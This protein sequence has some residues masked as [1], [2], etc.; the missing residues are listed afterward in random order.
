MF[1][2]DRYIVVALSMKTCGV[3]IS[4][5][6]AR[7]CIV[8]ADDEGTPQAVVVKTKKL[9]LGD[10]ILDKLGGQRWQPAISQAS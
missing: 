3:E 5:R 6:E 10:I 2:I 4:N 8:E 9:K 1:M 7:L